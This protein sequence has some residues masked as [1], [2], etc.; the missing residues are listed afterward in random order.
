[1]LEETTQIPWSYP[2]IWWCLKSRR[3]YRCK[4]GDQL[5]QP[6]K[7]R[8][9]AIQSLLGCCSLREGERRGCW[10]RGN[11]GSVPVLRVSWA[12]WSAYGNSFVLLEKSL[13]DEITVLVIDSSSLCWLAN[14]LYSVWLRR[15]EVKPELIF[16]HELFTRCDIKSAEHHLYLYFA[17]LWRY[18]V[19]ISGFIIWWYNF[20]AYSLCKYS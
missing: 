13:T 8:F 16:S 18:N 15:W 1:M 4:C 11:R 3:L 9:L 17:R 20:H 7:C 19:L 14:I 10:R 5:R 6:Q 2:I 12:G